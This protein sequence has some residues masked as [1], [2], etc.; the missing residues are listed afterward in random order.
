MSKKI[1][2]KI[3]KRHGDPVYDE[4]EREGYNQKPGE[5]PLQTLGRTAV[6]DYIAK[7]SEGHDRDQTIQ[8]AGVSRE[9][10]EEFLADAIERS[11]HMESGPKLKS[12]HDQ[13]IIEFAQ[14]EF[15]SYLGIGLTVQEAR[16]KAMLEVADAFQN[17]DGTLVTRSR[18]WIIDHLKD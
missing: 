6:K 7:K 17:K 14:K 10:A 2:K 15:R 18:S 4:V 8:S 12:A 5:T 9:L 11:N 1:P 16:A 13:E 3:E